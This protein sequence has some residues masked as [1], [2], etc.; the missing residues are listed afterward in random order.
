M[1]LWFLPARVTP[2]SARNPAAKDP[3]MPTQNRIEFPGADR[4]MLAGRIDRPV[5]GPKAW[6]AACALLFLFEGFAC[7]K[8]DGRTA[9]RAWDWSHAL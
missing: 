6:A 8:T 5:A 9:K 4:Q 3:P 7:R 2:M 1:G